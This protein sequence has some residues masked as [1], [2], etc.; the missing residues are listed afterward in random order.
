ME[1]TEKDIL[2]RPS[3]SQKNSTL[4]FIICERRSHRPFL[5]F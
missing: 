1:T 5:S 2:F 3:F 4:T